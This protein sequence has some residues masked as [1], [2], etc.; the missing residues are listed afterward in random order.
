MWHTMIS[1]RAVKVQ[2]S[3]K[4]SLPALGRSRTSRQSSLS[5]PDLLLGLRHNDGPTCYS[6]L[7]HL[8]S[9]CNRM[10][11][12]D[13]GKLL[14]LTQAA[15]RWKHLIIV[16]ISPGK[17]LDLWKWTGAF[18][19]SLQQRADI[20]VKELYNQPYIFTQIDNR[21]GQICIYYFCS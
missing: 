4:S 15:C 9:R 13:K 7:L 17:E 12:S 5:Q 19:T 18:Q 20:T 11:L 6:H 1:Y 21:E 16:G 14:N 2:V 3:M 8:L 10:G